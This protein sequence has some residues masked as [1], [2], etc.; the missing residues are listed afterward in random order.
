MTNIQLASF[1]DTGLI[2]VDSRDLNHP[3]LANF[4]VNFVLSLNKI[5]TNIKIGLIT[6]GNEEKKIELISDGKT[7]DLSF[8]FYVYAS[9]N[10][11]HFNDQ[12]NYIFKKSNTLF[13]TQ[14]Q[15]MAFE[16]SNLSNEYNSIFVRRASSNN[17]LE[18]YPMI[19][20]DVFSDR[21]LFSYIY[22]RSPLIDKISQDCEIPSLNSEVYI[23]EKKYLL[24]EEIGIGGEGCV[25]CITD[26]LVAK[27][28]N[29]EH[30]TKTR[31]E[32]ISMMVNK[33]VNDY[34]ICWPISEVRNE[35]NF[36]VGYTMKKCVGKPISTLYRGPIISKNLYPKFS[37]IDLIDICVKVLRKIE[38]LHRNNVL[39]A[40]I[41]DRNFLIND[42]KEVFLIDTDSYQIEDY[43]CEVGTI[44]YIAPELKGGTLGSNLRTFEDEGY[45]ISVFIFR[46][47]MHG[48]FPFAQVGTDLDYI[49]LIKKQVFPYSLKDYSTKK[50]VPPKAFELWS[51]I[52]TM[53]KKM[54]I[55]TFMFDKKVKFQ[56]RYIVEQWVIALEHYKEVLKEESE[57]MAYK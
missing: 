6:F 42:E 44:G 1:V 16:V 15:E 38:K 4:L 17:L 21:P 45:S 29:K 10:E 51:S 46:T 50:K 47:L 18:S 8:F 33:R 20:G 39:L 40:D 36:I 26:E 31:V 12:L 23:D 49:Q 19:I 41:N 22:G 5:G 3:N 2:L 25:Y 7:Y 52:P 56:N 24:K 54:F 13:L 37:N 43:C 14:N 11:N 53:L 27:I 55:Q 30:L 28:Y 9:I 35:D 57:Q 48:Y 32:K 34:S